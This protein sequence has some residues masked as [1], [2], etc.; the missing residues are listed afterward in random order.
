M[1]IKL[2]SFLIT[3]VFGASYA[4]AYNYDASTDIK[5]PFQP[6]Q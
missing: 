6:D 1:K 3:T 4:Q 2:I 5:L